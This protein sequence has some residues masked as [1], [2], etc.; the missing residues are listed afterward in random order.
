MR[1]WLKLALL[2][3]VTLVLPWDGV[4][5]ARQ[6][7]AALRQSERQDLRSLAHTLAASLQ[8]RTRLIYRYPAQGAEPGAYDLT[9]VL[10]P[11][12]VYVDG[13]AAGW[14]RA[15]RLWRRYG[16][17]ARHF[18]ILTGVNGR[19]LFVL[20]RVSDPHVV[21]AAPRANPLDRNS[22]GDRAWIGF[23]GPLGR[24]HAEFL[25]LTGTGPVVAR[26]IVHG[27]YGRLRVIADPRIVGALR[28]RPGGYD[29]ELSIPL[30]MLG[31]AFGVQIDDRN[32]LGHT[33]VRYGMLRRKSL[34]PRGGLILASTVLP[35]YLHRLLRPGLR[36][37]VATPAG[38]L[39]A[40]ADRSTVPNIPAPQPGLLARLF[41]RLVGPGGTAPI[42]AA[43]SVRG[44][45]GRGVIARL[46]IAQTSNRWAELRDRT[47]ERMLN[48]TLATSAV[49]FLVA[50]LLASQMMARAWRRHRAQ[51][52]GGSRRT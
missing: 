31:G 30:S 16:S 34:R 21:F 40:Q 15:R 35:S 8:G 39:L 17:R 47:L 1:P 48:L 44:I 37:S 4:R 22:R 29:L 43:A 24:D 50:I 7:E 6:M 52:P 14:P 3:L 10:L 38:A 26:R 51:H 11:T 32:G 41:R 36:L 20:L 9:P 23:T 25:A 42:A 2:V 45:G 12:P 5:Y 28:A 46:E 33:P 13:Y 18:D 27:E 19:A 49:T